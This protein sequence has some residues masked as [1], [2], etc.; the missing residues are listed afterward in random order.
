MTN[1]TEDSRLKKDAD[2]DVVNRRDTRRAQNREVTENRDVSEDD[3][4]EMFRNQLFNDALPDL[5][6]IPGYH[7]C[8]LTTTNPRD[9]IHRRMQL[10]YEPVKPT[11]VPGMEYASVKTGEWTGFI[12]VNEMLAF[13][14]PLSL[15]EK[16]M[17]EAHHNAPL[18]EEDKLAEV[19]DMMREQA[20]RAGSTM[21][22][23]DGITDM[24]DHAPRKGVFT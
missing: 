18:R 9:P 21:Y 15:Y 10:G 23:G 12:G 17:Q 16:F 20:E 7:L 5:P 24:R 3:R 2:F 1:S 13:K 4:L 6:E 11:E 8:W 19:A 14:L 22:E